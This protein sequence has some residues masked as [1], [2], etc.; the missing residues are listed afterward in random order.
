MLGAGRQGAAI[1]QPA[2]ALHPRCVL[3]QRLLGRGIDD[4]ADIGGDQGRVADR[5]LGHRA[6]QHRQQPVGDVGL[7]IEQ[8]R[9]R[10][11][12][13]GAV[14][15]RGQDIGDDLLGERRGIDDHRV[16]PAGLG[17]ERHDRPGTARQFEVDMARGLG[18]SGKGDPG[19]ARVGDERRADRLAGPRQQMQNLA[20]DPRLEQQPH[21][22]GGDQRRLLGGLGDDRVAGGERRGDLAGEDRQRKIPR[23]DAGEDAAPVQLDLVALAGRAGQGAAGP[24][25][26]ARART[27]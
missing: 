22:G 4:R 13:P 25:K 15:G 2:L 10:A 18:R 12:L 26:S 27:A 14:E 3:L 19:D 24:A 11:A 16:L 5:Q 8:A 17:D 21:R 20:G 1:D 6:R 23:R 7:H 9:R